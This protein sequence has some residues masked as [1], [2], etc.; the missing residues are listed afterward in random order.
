MIE[1]INKILLHK[2]LESKDTLYKCYL[3][4]V[5]GLRREIAACCAGSGMWLHWLH[6]MK[7]AF[8]LRRHNHI[9]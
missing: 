4:K 6:V 2:G 7:L 9:K 5:Q 3:L 8:S 1:A